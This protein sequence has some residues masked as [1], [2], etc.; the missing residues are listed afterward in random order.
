MPNLHTL[1]VKAAPNKADLLDKIWMKVKPEDK[2]DTVIT[3][4]VNLTQN[5]LNTLASTLLLLDNNKKQELYR[6]KPNIF[7][8]I[9]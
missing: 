6:S 8:S 2:I 4:V 7:V 3:S 9:T 1:A 5:S